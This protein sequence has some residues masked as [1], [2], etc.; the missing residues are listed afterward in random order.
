MCLGTRLCCCDW[1]C[2]SFSYT[3]YPLEVLLMCIKKPNTHPCKSLHGQ[4]IKVVLFK[5][6]CFNWVPHQVEGDNIPP[7]YDVSEICSQLCIMRDSLT[8]P[9]T[10]T[11]TTNFKLWPGWLRREASQ[12][13]HPRHVHH[14]ATVD[15]S[16]RWPSNCIT[17]PCSVTVW[18]SVDWGGLLRSDSAHELDFYM[19]NYISLT[20]L[21]V[22]YIFLA[23]ELI[24]TF[25]LPHSLQFAH[26]Y[27][28]SGSLKGNTF[29]LLCLTFVLSLLFVFFFVCCRDK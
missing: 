29:V 27:T 14:R 13:L 26:S 2:H 15:G 7:L 23:F 24:I 12:Y 19:D 28:N 25:I 3:S 21:P 8:T 16:C 4:Q 17:H 5:S 11:Q 1:W 10:Q 6:I 22:Q 18:T 20:F 9:Q